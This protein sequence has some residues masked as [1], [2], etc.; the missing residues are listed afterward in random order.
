[1]MKPGLREVVPA[2]R[3]FAILFNAADKQINPKAG[4]RSIISR[5]PIDTLL[6]GDAGHDC[7]AHLLDLCYK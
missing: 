2:L 4:T 5:P 3:P 6:I 7:R 1:M